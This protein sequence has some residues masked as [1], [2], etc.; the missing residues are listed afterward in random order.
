MSVGGKGHAVQIARPDGQGGLEVVEEGLQ[1][2][3]KLDKVHIV[4]VVGGYHTGKS[5]L[6]NQLMGQGQVRRTHPFSFRR[7]IRFDVHPP[8][9]I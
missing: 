6:L 1:L 5:F 2:L 7:L 3:G 4:S 8:F 9:F